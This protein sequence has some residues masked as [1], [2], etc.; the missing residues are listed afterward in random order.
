VAVSLLTKPLDPDYLDR[1]FNPARPEEPVRAVGA[2][3]R[4][5]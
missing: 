2:T 5:S 1:I 4:S 3:G